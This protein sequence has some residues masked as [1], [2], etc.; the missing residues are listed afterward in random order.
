M[1]PVARVMD[2]GRFS[3]PRVCNNA[4]RIS[5]EEKT[6]AVDPITGKVLGES[7]QATPEEES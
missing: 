1:L 7:D 2:Q 4:P 3:W 6:V 5:V